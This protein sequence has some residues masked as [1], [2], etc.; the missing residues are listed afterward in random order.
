[1]MEIIKLG[2][3]LVVDWFLDI[4]LLEFLEINFFNLFVFGSFL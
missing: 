3:E 2:I 1:M 4:Y